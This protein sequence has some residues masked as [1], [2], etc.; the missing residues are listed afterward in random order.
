MSVRQTEMVAVPLVDHLSRIHSMEL[1]WSSLFKTSCSAGTTIIIEGISANKLRTKCKQELANYGEISVIRWNNGIKEQRFR[2]EV[3]YTSTVCAVAAA[4]ALDGKSLQ[5]R[6]LRTRIKITAK[7]W[8]I[9][10]SLC[11]MF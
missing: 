1:K 6:R 9:H 8:Y 11:E 3:T 2:C 5:R 4:I 7:E 10:R